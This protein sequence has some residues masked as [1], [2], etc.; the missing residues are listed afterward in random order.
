MVAAA[1]AAAAAAVAAAAL[2]LLLL[3]LHRRTRLTLLHLN[4][5]GPVL[6]CHRGCR[7]L[8]NGARG[9]KATQAVV[10]EEGEAREGTDPIDPPARTKGG[11][12][13]DGGRKKEDKDTRPS[14]ESVHV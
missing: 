14:C 1:A 12:R 10:V 13:K 5:A 7:G 4:K 3:R 9:K 11:K 6:P 2:Y 8:G